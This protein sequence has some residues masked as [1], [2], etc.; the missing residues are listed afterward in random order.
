M[1]LSQAESR[2]HMMEFNMCKIYKYNTVRKAI[3]VY[4]NAWELK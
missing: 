2:E 1:Y 3:K 4:I